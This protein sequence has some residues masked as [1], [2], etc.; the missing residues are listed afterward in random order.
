M[1]PEIECIRA[2]CAA[3]QALPTADRRT[4]DRVLRFVTEWWAAHSLAEEKEEQSAKLPG[5]ADM[6]RLLRQGTSRSTVPF[7]KLIGPSL[8]DR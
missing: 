5:V 1:D 7:D 4:R 2:M 3:T 6:E 8:V